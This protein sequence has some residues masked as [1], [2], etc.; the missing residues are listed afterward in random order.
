MI[1]INTLTGGGQ[2][3]LPNLPP[4][5]S[6]LRVAQSQTAKKEQQ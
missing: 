5:S 2:A 6:S 3:P 4:R 1:D